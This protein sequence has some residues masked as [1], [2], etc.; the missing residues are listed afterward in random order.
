M[1]VDALD[2]AGVEPDPR[3]EQEMALVDARYIHRAGLPL[4]GQ[5]QQV[6]GGVDDVGRDSQHP[7][8]D[9]RTPSGEG[10]QGGLRSDQA[11]GRLVD[12]AVP[13]ERDDH[14]VALACRL[15]A[16]RGGVVARLGLDR[17]D[18]IAPAQRVYDEVLEAVG[19]GRRVRVDDDQHP[20]ARGVRP[21]RGA[22]SRAARGDRSSRPACS[23]LNT[24]GERSL[25]DARRPRD[26]T[27]NRPAA[28]ILPPHI[29]VRIKRGGGTGPVKPRQPPA[30]E[31]CQ[32][33]Q[34]PTTGLGDVDSGGFTGP[35]T[36]DPGGGFF[37]YAA[38]VS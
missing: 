25:R 26:A 36:T 35:P 10:A 13:A 11:V 27:P 31:R 1:G 2:D 37:T 19:D 3:G 23:L 34:A 38:R 12:G 17:L 22:L 5:P 32:F 4:V 33:H 20:L 14:V 24:G 15:A 8:V 6:L 21:R 18:L 7:A 30:R 9:V 16:Q 29:A 28:C